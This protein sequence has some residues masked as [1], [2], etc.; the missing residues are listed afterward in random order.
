MHKLD[1]IVAYKRQELAELKANRP[2]SVVERGLKKRPPVRS[3]QKSIRREGRLSLIAEVKRASPS[4]GVIRRG[5]DP[6]AIAKTYAG[7]GAQAISVLTDEK[8][9]SGKLSELT[10]VKEAVRVPVLRKDFTLE[11]YQVVEGAAAG[12]DCILLIVAL[13]EQSVLARLA[14]LAQDLSLDVITEVHTDGEVSRA[15]DAGAQIIGI[16]N[17][18]LATFKV[19]LATTQRLAGQLSKEWTLVSES[20]IRLPEDV[21]FV[22]AQG[23]HAVLVGEALMA[24]EDVAQQVKTLMGESQCG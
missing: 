1:E 24:S 16:N 8:F 23:V 19:D 20:G 17:R 3:F 12:A 18:D 21:A 13:L 7:A 14:A 5:A 15:L 11:E 6:V 10:A 4:A 9:F 2:L 22:R